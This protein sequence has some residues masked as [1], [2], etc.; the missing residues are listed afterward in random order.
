[1]TLLEI[2]VALVILSLGFV[3]V[4]GG[5]LDAV[6]GS[7]AHRE[8]AVSET[9]LRL[10]TEGVA[11]SALHPAGGKLI[12]CQPGNTLIP[13]HKPDPPID[14]PMTFCV[15]VD[16]NE[17]F[18]PGAP[19]TF[20]LRVFV[21]GEGFIGGKVVSSNLS[22]DIKVTAY[23]N[24]AESHAA[25]ER[26]TQYVPCPKAADVNRMYYTGAK[27]NPQTD[28]L[29]G[30]VVG[31]RYWTPDSGA[32]APG[33]WNQN[34]AAELCK[35]DGVKCDSGVA[36]VTIGV[37]AAGASQSQVPP[38]GDTCDPKG[39]WAACTQMYLRTGDL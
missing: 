30:Q 24:G 25:N 34:C 4:I 31:I 21:E 9:K 15:R 20:P 2:L 29:P 27:K 10:F 19:A 18:P 11:A 17:Q 23:P 37:L 1:M 8:Y 6:A 7:K 5:M 39:L 3:A 36:R 38:N 12:P 32:G 33:N 35:N 26:V 22:G 14:Q 13:A 16:T 28:P